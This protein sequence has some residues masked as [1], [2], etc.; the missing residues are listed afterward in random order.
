MKKTSIRHGRVLL[1]LLVLFG[2]I[3][4][5][6]VKGQKLKLSSISVN[7]G[8]VGYSYFPNFINLHKSAFGYGGVSNSLYPVCINPGARFF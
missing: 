1:L 3:K 8:L 5:E 6:P 7:N 2:A 4:P